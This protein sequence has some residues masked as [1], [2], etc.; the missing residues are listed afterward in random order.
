M[1][2]MTRLIFDAL[3]SRDGLKVFTDEH[4]SSSSV[5]LQFGIKDGGSYRIRFISRDDGNDVAVRAYSLISV[6][7]SHRTKVLT[8]LNELNYK[9][10]YIKLILDSDG[11][12]NLEYD[13]PVHCPDPAA[14]AGE[15]I[16]RFTKIIDDIYP[17]LMRA[18]RA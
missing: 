4:K 16:D 10:R 18:L 7:Q 13:Y 2:K 17:E 11:D 9:Y 6:D 1:Y 8:V 15:L 3:K 5:W 12:V 14:S